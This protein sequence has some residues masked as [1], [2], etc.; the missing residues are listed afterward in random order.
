M[1]RQTLKIGLTVAGTL[2]LLTSWLVNA[3]QDKQWRDDVIATGTIVR[4]ADSVIVQQLLADPQTLWSPLTLP[5]YEQGERSIEYASG[6]ALWYHSGKDPVAIRWLLLRDPEGQFDPQALLCTDATQL[7]YNIV[8]WF[9][10]RW[11]VEVTFQEARL[12]LGLETQRQWSDKAIART[13][14]ILLGLFAWITL[15]V[16]YLTIARDCPTR[17]AAWYH[18]P[19]PTFSEAKQSRR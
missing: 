6:T 13:T 4:D 2:V 19:L 11:C 5:W 18:K 16:H 17:R 7:P 9:T 3:N 8:C 10:R 1:K 12:H 15:V 14:P